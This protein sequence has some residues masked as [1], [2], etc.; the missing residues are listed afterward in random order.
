MHVEYSMFVDLWQ[1]IIS[2]L[3]LHSFYRYALIF[4]ICFSRKL[5]PRYVSWVGGGRGGVE[6]EDIFAHPRSHVYQKR[7]EPSVFW[8]LLRAVLPTCFSR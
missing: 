7:N 8:V 3:G 5:S 6:V 2:T 1:W 4:N